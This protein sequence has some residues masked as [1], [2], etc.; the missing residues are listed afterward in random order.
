MERANVQVGNCRIRMRKPAAADSDD[1]DEVYAEFVDWLTAAN[2]SI[3]QNEIDRM[4]K[5]HTRRT[6][7]VT[8][9]MGA[10]HFYDVDMVYNTAGARYTAKLKPGPSRHPDRMRSRSR[11]AERGQ[12]AQ[13]R[14]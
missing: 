6:N 2:P 12:S 13:Y 9:Y 1:H 7:P 11:G 3:E 5:V 8:L 10:F 4:W 14:L